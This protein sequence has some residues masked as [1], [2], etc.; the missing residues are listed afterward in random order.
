MLLEVSWG[1]GWHGWGCFLP[2]QASPHL[3]RWGHMAAR[4]EVRAGVASLLGGRTQAKPPRLT[5][6]TD[7]RRAV[8]AGEALGWGEYRGSA[9]LLSQQEP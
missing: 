8:D 6:D 4:C 9:H 7:F 5:S 2:P 3:P 1:R